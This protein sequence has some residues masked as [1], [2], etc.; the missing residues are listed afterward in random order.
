MVRHRVRSLP[1]SV[2]SQHEL[3][4]NGR[5]GLIWEVRRTTFFPKSCAYFRSKSLVSLNW[6]TS[7]PSTAGSASSLSLNEGGDLPEFTSDN[8]VEKASR[9]RSRSSS[10]NSTGNRSQANEAAADQVSLGTDAQEKDSTERPGDLMAEPELA[11]TEKSEPEPV[12]EEGD[13]EVF[14]D[15]SEEAPNNGESTQLSVIDEEKDEAEGAHLENLDEESDDMSKLSLEA[16]AV[17]FK[18]EDDDDNDEEET[19]SA[20][21]FS[22]PTRQRPSAPALLMHTRGQSMSSLEIRIPPSY[23]QPETLSAVGD[24][25]ASTV[26][27][28]Q[29]SAATQSSKLPVRRGLSSSFL[30][31]RDPD[32]TNRP[33]SQNFDALEEGTVLVALSSSSSSVASKGLDRSLSAS[34]PSIDSAVNELVRGMG[35]LLSHCLSNA[36][37]GNFTCL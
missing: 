37:W 6:N 26:S 34:T 20:G 17:S 10:S 7:S 21:D 24:S 29:T 22:I 4:C 30:T 19:I 23:S 2:S 11:E 18:E 35:T 33:V 32:A 31:N 28:A 13:D 9:E 36:N 12:R 1:G 8:N 25:G 5:Y 15:C 3:G 16:V 14:R 27:T